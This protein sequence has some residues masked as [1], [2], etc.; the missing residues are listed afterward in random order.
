VGTGDTLC[1][2]IYFYLASSRESTQKLQHQD[3]SSPPSEEAL[4]NHAKAI[5]KS[6]Q[7]EDTEMINEHR[8][9]AAKKI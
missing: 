5:A 2:E 1:A 9:N 8:M 4:R 7:E 3:Y 6:N